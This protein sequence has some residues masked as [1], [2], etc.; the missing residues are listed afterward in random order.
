MFS[1][2]IK[3]ELRIRS[4]HNAI[5]FYPS[6]WHLFLCFLEH[7]LSS[8]LSASLFIDIPYNTILKQ[9]YHQD[10]RFMASRLPA[11]HSSPL[12]A[13][14][15]L[16]SS[17]HY[18]TL[19]LSLHRIYQNAKTSLHAC[20]IPRFFNLFRID[21]L[22]RTFTPS[23]TTIRLMFLVLPGQH[24]LLHTWYQACRPEVPTFSLTETGLNL[25][26]NFVT[27]LQFPMTILVYPYFSD[28]IISY[29]GLISTETTYCFFHCSHV[30]YTHS[31]TV[32]QGFIEGCFIG[33]PETI[34]I[35]K[36]GETQAERNI[37]IELFLA[38]ISE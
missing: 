31:S 35:F 29:T 38:T 33:P 32:Y 15:C 17:F 30:S 34:F 20:C 10:D 26:E 5:L 4:A 1:S 24:H 7:Q 6:F 19:G 23:I 16:L 21:Q 14:S 25:S 8:S 22:Y 28:S 36:T 11:L 13:C 27:F 9:K 2:N 12:S 3:T 37:P 18:N